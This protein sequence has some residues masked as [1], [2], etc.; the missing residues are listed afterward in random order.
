MTKN[1]LIYDAR[2]ARYKELLEPLFPDISIY[3]ATTEEE[4]IAIVGNAHELFALGHLFSDDLVSRAAKL[5]WAQ[6]LTT[7]VDGVFMLTALSNDIILTNARGIHGPQ[8]SEMAFM[9]MLALTRNFPRMVHNQTAAKWDRWPQAL[10]HEKTITIVG[11]GVIAE[12][13][14]PKCKAF[15]MTVYGVSGTKRDVPGFDRMFGRDELIKAASLSDYLLLLVPY[16][17]ETDKLVDA[18]VLAAMK[19]DAYIVNLARG[20]VLDEDALMDVLRAGKIAG[21]GLDVFAER[22]LPSDHPF[23]SMDNVLITPQVGGMSATYQDQMVPILEQNIR[24]FLRR[25]F[26][27]MVNV[28]DHRLLDAPA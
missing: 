2:A 24:H 26:D 3:T 20:G 12:D 19:P 10:L 14:A 25:E 9:H 21:A 4:A 11:V 17:A 6:A 8:M 15:N 27:K 18:D 7:G 23:W 1:L 16:S 13:L 5:E 28:V 22:P